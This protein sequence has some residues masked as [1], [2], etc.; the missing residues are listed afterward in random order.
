[1]DEW[2]IGWM[3]SK[4][5]KIWMN[6]NWVDDKLDE[7]KLSD[8]NCANKNC[9]KNVRMKIEFIKEWTK[10]FEVERMLLIKWNEL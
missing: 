7:W 2:N 1:M 4:G 9:S 5:M 3:K 10:L 6:E 8:E